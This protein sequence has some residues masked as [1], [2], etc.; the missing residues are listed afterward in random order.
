MEGMVMTQALPESTTRA[1]RPESTRR[2]TWLALLVSALTL[3]G[4]APPATA[5]GTVKIGVV[6]DLTGPAA[7]LGKPSLDAMRLAVEHTN[8]AGGL[9][10]RR[11]ELIV[12]DTASRPDGAA[13]AL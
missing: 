5:Q 7:A 13:R 1:P 3:L 9:L 2:S 4:L 10:G 12:L 6:T 11:L 8:R